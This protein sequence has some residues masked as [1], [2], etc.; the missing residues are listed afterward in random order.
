MCICI[1]RIALRERGGQLVGTN[2]FL[3]CVGGDRILS[4]ALWG[5]EMIYS[6]QIST[7]ILESINKSPF[8]G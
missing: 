5:D 1:S 8:T 3:L 2:L 6:K 4:A 7:W